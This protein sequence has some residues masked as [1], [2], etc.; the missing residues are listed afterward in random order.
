VI[1]AGTVASLNHHMMPIRAG[2]FAPAADQKF[3]VVER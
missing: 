3:Y 2:W 1:G